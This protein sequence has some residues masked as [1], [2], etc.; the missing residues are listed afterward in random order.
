MHLDKNYSII[1]LTI[2]WVIWMNN[3]KEVI[4]LCQNYYKIVNFE[5]D[6]DDFISEKLINIYKDY[7]FK[8]NINN[9]DDVKTAKKMDEVLNKYID[10][11]VF[12]KEMNKE[13]LKVKISRSCADILKAIVDSI[14][15]IFNHYQEYTTR[16]IYV[17][18]WI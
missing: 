1:E 9:N 17:S 15:A 13:L 6:E 10:D 8:I 5:Y 14:L 11:Y 7:L 2:E 4:A 12:R 18:R 3:G 16:N